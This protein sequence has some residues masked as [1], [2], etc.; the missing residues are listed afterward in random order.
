MTNEDSLFSLSPASRLLSHP[1][2]Q[3]QIK[4]SI[5]APRHWPLSGEITGDW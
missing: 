1:F 2:I 3:E 4:E 5:K